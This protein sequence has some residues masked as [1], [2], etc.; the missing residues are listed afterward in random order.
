MFMYYFFKDF[1]QHQ[2]VYGCLC[3]SVRFFVLLEWSLLNLFIERKFLSIS[4]TCGL[5]I[6]YYS[7]NNWF[8]GQNHSNRHYV[9]FEQNIIELRS[10]LN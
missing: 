3:F 6:K 5:S 10:I 8:H 4:Q 2:F 9:L 7:I 1:G